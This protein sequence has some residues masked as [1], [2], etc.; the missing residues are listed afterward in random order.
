MMS[1]GH[2]THQANKHYYGGDKRIRAKGKAGRNLPAKRCV[3]FKNKDSCP[4][5]KENNENN[6]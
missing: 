4:Y 1:G 6:N 3:Y 2:C 5:L